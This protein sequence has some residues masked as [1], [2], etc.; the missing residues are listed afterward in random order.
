VYH[1]NFLV[2]TSKIFWARS[3]TTVVFLVPALTFMAD[4]EG[5]VLLIEA[6]NIVYGLHVSTQKLF[7]RAEE[8]KQKLRE[9]AERSR[10]IRDDEEKRGNGQIYYISK[11]FN[12]IW[13]A[14]TRCQSQ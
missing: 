10:K 12:Y 13:D 5:A 9:V 14:R 6:L 1:I 2:I 4:P 7:V 8:I 3:F 11:S